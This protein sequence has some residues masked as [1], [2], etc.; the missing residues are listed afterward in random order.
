MGTVLRLAIVDP[1][2]R[3]RDALK[4]MLLRMDTVWLEAECSRYEFFCDVVS[5][6]HPDVGIVSIDEN[7]TRAISLIEQLRDMGDC[8]VVVVSSTNDGEM[9]LRACGLGPR[10]SS[11][12][13]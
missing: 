13:P 8:S 10:S 5:Q 4:N 1:N 2:D 9:I 3:S 12:S 7:P 6:S 11:R